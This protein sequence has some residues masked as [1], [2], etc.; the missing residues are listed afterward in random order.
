M[1]QKLKILAIVLMFTTFAMSQQQKQT[2]K[3]LTPEERAQKR[4][5]TLKAKLKLTD[6]QYN[7][8]YLQLVTNEKKIKA[9]REELKKAREEHDAKMKS[10]LTPEQYSQLK[11]MQA[12]RKE[13]MKGKRNQEEHPVD[14]FPTE[15]K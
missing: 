14:D 1:K 7:Q 3:N 15:Q 5:E 10:I 13:M 6:V 9:Q 12:Q 11:E 2:G 8:V 4:T